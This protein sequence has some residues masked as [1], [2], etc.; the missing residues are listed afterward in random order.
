MPCNFVSLLLITVSNCV[1]SD[2]KSV[3]RSARYCLAI[4]ASCW[5]W[6]QPLEPKSHVD[7]NNYHQNL[8][9]DIAASFSA[10]NFDHGVLDAAKLRMD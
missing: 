1:I 5:S 3:R 4:S 10:G 9:D 7:A 8:D 2:S 6:N